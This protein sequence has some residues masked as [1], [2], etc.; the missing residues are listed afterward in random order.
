M[1]R[2]L[3]IINPCAGKMKS[4]TALFDIVDILCRKYMVTT[5]VTTHRGHAAELACNAAKT[6]H[7]LLVCCGGDGTLNEV[8][9]GNMQAQK[10]LPIGYIPAGSTNDF[11]GSAGLP[12]DPA[13]AAAM[14]AEGKPTPLDLGRFDDDRYFTYTASFGAF[15]AAS[16]KAPQPA[17]N[18]FGHMAYLLEGVKDIGKIKPYHIRAQAGDGT[19]YEGDYV[20]GA[21]CNST[22]M[23]GMV[24]FKTDIVD[25]ADG[26]FEV[27]LVKMP[28]SLVELRQIVHALTRLD[29]HHEMI[30]LFQGAEIRFSLPEALPWSLDGECA[31]GGESITIVNQ[32]GALQLIR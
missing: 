13:A 7:S 1:K 11:A 2:I 25:M 17:K 27:V 30:D 3:L 26:R 18:M 21:V 20:F 19:V 23:A 4:K 16:Y 10:P 22:Q 6:G 14:I 28:A 9:N 5:Q 24:K 32:P 29:F 8:V 15:T 31:S 12:T